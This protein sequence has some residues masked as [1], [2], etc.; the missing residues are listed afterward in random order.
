MSNFKRRI[1]STEYI[2]NK[3]VVM[4][5]ISD[6][7]DLDVIGFR[8]YNPVTIDFRDPCSYAGLLAN[9][10]FH[11]MAGGYIGEKSNQITNYTNRINFAC[12][13]YEWQALGAR[14]MV[15]GINYGIGINTFY[16]V[17]AITHAKSIQLHISSTYRL[18]GP[19]WNNWLY[20]EEGGGTTL[21]TFTPL[22]SRDIST[23]KIKIT[24][25]R[26]NANLK[27]YVFS[28]WDRTTGLVWTYTFDDTRALAGDSPI[29]WGFDEE[30]GGY[31]SADGYWSSI[32]SFSVADTDLPLGANTTP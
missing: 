22:N 30:A 12:C 15:P 25:T 21:H 26:I 23:G 9:G 5:E 27:R 2:C 11:M 19:A 32:R 10:A 14:N 17:D 16:A 3:S 8:S 6:V 13:V 1:F 31:D 20:V 4:S 24:S 18:P 7:T 28:G 29:I